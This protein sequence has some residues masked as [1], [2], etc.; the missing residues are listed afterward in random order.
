[1]VQRDV[2][3][4]E[5]HQG[6]QLYREGTECLS[7]YCSATCS[8]QEVGHQLRVGRD[9]CVC[10]KAVQPAGERPGGWCGTLEWVPGEERAGRAAVLRK[11]TVRKVLR[12]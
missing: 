5:L 10:R 6:H 1:M 4:L 8:N 9:V 2:G 11:V 3:V 12:K 7:Q